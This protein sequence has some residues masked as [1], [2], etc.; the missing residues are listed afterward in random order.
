[1][2][3]APASGSVGAPPAAAPPALTAWL[4]AAVS[5]D[6]QQDALDCAS[7]VRLLHERAQ[8]GG[9]EPALLHASVRLGLALDRG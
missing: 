2:R 7:Q 3:A 5:E 9:L 4:C 8:L 1:M 6:L